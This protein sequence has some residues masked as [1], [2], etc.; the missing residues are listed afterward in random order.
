[1]KQEE[2]FLLLLGVPVWGPNIHDNGCAIKESYHT[3]VGGAVGEGFLAP[4]PFWSKKSIFI[5]T[6]IKNFSF[7]I[8]IT[9]AI[10]YLYLGVSPFLACGL[11]EARDES[12]RCLLLVFVNDA[13]AIFP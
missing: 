7:A 11:Q 12:S 2:I 4:L 8:F 6:Q 3:E 1:M 5:D 9:T 13:F 10:L